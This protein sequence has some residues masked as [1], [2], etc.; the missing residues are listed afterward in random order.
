LEEIDALYRQAMRRWPGLRFRSPL[1][2][3]HCLTRQDDA[4]VTTALRQ[5]LA[6]WCARAGSLRRFWRLARVTELAVLIR[7]AGAWASVR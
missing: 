1:E 6:A 7:M 5:H 4:L 2:L 3:Q